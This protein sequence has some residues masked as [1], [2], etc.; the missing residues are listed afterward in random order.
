MYIVHIKQNRVS[1]KTNKQ[2]IYINIKYSYES[3]ETF[4]NLEY[5]KPSS[6]TC[7]NFEIVDKATEIKP[8]I[9]AKLNAL[10]CTL[11]APTAHHPRR[12]RQ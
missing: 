7:F 10:M 2:F 1:I 3:R 6:K 11:S 5:K 4:S 9:R 8:A 12:R